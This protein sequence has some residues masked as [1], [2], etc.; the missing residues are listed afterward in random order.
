[1]SDRVFSV[2]EALVDLH[3]MR[4]NEREDVSDSLGRGPFLSSLRST[5]LEP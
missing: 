1:V 5:Q 2:G 3:G 4:W